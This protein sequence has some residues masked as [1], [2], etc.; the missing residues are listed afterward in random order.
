MKNL[1]F[2][3]SL[4]LSLSIFAQGP[5]NPAAPSATVMNYGKYA[6]IMPNLYNGALSVPLSL[7]NVSEG[8][9]SHDVGLSYHTAGI[10]ANELAS[11]VGLGWVLSA[12]GVVSRT[13]RGLPDLEDEGGYIRLGTTLQGLSR[14]KQR[15]EIREGNI[16]GE[17][18]MFH[19]NFGGM[20]GK[21][22]R[23][24]NG[25]IHTI[26]KSDVRIELIC[27]KRFL[28][29]G[30]CSTNPGPNQITG[31][32]ITTTDGNKYH[33]G[34]AIINNSLTYA[35]DSSKYHNEEFY[36]SSWHL[37]KINTHDNLHEITFEYEDDAYGFHVNE[38]CEFISYTE[39]NSTEQIDDTDC[40]MQKRRIVVWQ[41]L[42]SQINTSTGI[43][44]FNYEGDRADLGISSPEFYSLVGPKRLESIDCKEGIYTKSYSL[45]QSYFE[46][47]FTSNTDYSIK[48]LKLDSITI[49]GGSLKEPS[50]S[51]DYYRKNGLTTGSFFFP[52][53]TSKAI[54]HWGFY[55][56]A[57]QNDDDDDI[58]PNNTIVSFDTPAGLRVLS[59]GSSYRTTEE[60]HMTSGMLRKI[61]FPLGGSTTYEYEAN[62]YYNQDTFITR[63]PL[64]ENTSNSTFTVTQDMYDSGKLILSSLPSSLGN[65]SYS[66]VSFSINGNEINRFSITAENLN[67]ENLVLDIETETNLQPNTTY[68]INFLEFGGP[69]T[70]QIEYSTSGYNEDIGGLRVKKITTYDGIDHSK[71]IIR[72]IEYTKEEDPSHSSGILFRKPLYAFDMDKTKRYI[73][74]TFTLFRSNSIT[75]LSSFEGYHVGYSTVRINHNGNGYQ[76][77]DFHVDK[78]PNTPRSYPIIPEL[79][80]SLLGLSKGSKTFKQDG[81]ELSNSKQQFEPT[82]DQNSPS[83]NWVV[84]YLDERL[85]TLDN[86][87]GTQFVN[88]ETYTINNG[89]YRPDSVF[90]TQD[91]VSTIQSFDYFSNSHLNATSSI[92]VDVQGLNEYEIISE[93]TSDYPESALS[94]RQSLIDRNI[95][96][97][98]KTTSKK[99]NLTLSE[100]EHTFA[101][102]EGHPRL[103]QTEMTYFEYDDDLINIESTETNT[104]DYK[105]YNAK[106]LLTA[107]QKNGYIIDNT[108]E[109]F[110]NSLLKSSAFGQHKKEFEY[111]A[112]TRLLSKVIEIDQTET[113]YT[114]D[115]LKRLSTVTECTG[116]QTTYAY[117]LTNNLSGLSRSSIQT[118]TTFPAD[119]TGMSNLTQLESFQYMDGLGRTLQT[120]GKGTSYEGLDQITAVEYDNQGRPHISF[121]TFQ[122]TYNDGA[123]VTEPDP[124]SRPHSLTKYEASPTSR[125]IETTP[126]G[127]FATRTEYGHNT[128][129]DMVPIDGVDNDIYPEG[130]LFKKTT[131]DPNGNKVITFTDESGRM[132][133]SRRVDDNDANQND[134]YYHYDYKD[135]NTIVVPPDAEV[136]DTELC[137]YY[138]YDTENRMVSKKVPSKGIIYM[139]YNERDLLVAQ[140]DSYLRLN[141]DKW[142]G[143]SPDEYGRPLGTGFL[144]NK[145]LIPEIIAINDVLSATTY[146]N[147]T[148]RAQR[149]GHY[150]QYRLA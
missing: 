46:D 59:A 69:G 120:V 49:S 98:F 127:W 7:A 27:E 19:Y 132:I 51:F 108:F 85:V 91:G 105:T 79:P 117:N 123:F 45:H 6:D 25:I 100:E 148:P 28:S 87:S 5:Q 90:V 88:F 135:R 125:P 149:E 66:S 75:P 145:P 54:D 42:L 109:Y 76:R 40:I 81:T 106:G 9:L 14:L 150:Y 147:N 22:Y 56:G 110:S 4:F 10:R 103:D 60:S 43:I 142:Y 64:I 86:R 53:L 1:V 68:T 119:P 12:G 93:Y 116:A 113:T 50:Y 16:D 39:L 33:F 41:R 95:I 83:L 37:L 92:T 48:R 29:T 15:Q 44:Q 129:A 2:L 21:F 107:F 101:L 71:D 111:E 114:Y 115:D 72:T 96:I 133:L 102:F 26:P 11:E 139:L 63:T 84:S 30:N 73:N 31:F 35:I 89:L 13:I 34:R 131:I 67:L 38:P 82:F 128:A 138:S 104:L 52:H 24:H 112:N 94:E 80:R 143:Y 97:P 36:N 118:T 70:F 140:Q 32:V 78:A 55:N 65:N 20:S 57:N 61:N 144:D 99:N 17:M 137:F 134:T 47:D 136:T 58:I 146:D 122:S 124:N 77:F 130:T 62:S 121:E 23:D 126:P 3:N 18:D 8:P 74:P 141:G